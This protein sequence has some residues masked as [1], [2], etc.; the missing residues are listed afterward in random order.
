MR[1]CLSVLNEFKNHTSNHRE[2]LG[3]YLVYPWEGFCKVFFQIRVVVYVQIKKNC[4]L[5]WRMSDF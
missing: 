1:M 2:I 5:P 4:L 3:N